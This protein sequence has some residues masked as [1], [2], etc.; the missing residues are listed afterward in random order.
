MNKIIYA[1]FFI[2]ILNSLITLQLI[3]NNSICGDEPQY[4]GYALNLINGNGFVYHNKYSWRPPGYPIFLAAIYSIFGLNSFTAVRIIQSILR[5]LCVFII[6]DL[7]ASNY[8]KKTGIIA[9]LLWAFEPSSLLISNY[10]LTETLFTVILLLTILLMNYAVKKMKLIFIFCG[11]FCY[12]CSLLISDRAIVLLPFIL[13]WLFITIP[14]RKKKVIYCTAL[15]L[16]SALFVSPWSVRNSLIHKQFVFITTHGGK[17]LWLYNNPY[18]PFIEGS[19]SSAY[20]KYKKVTTVMIKG[21]SEAERDKMMYYAGIN[22]IVTNPIIFLRNGVIKFVRFFR[23]YPIITYHTRL[24]DILIGW[25]SYFIIFPAFFVGLYLSFKNK[26]YSLL[27]IM[28]VYFVILHI[29]DQA[30]LRKRVPAMPFI[31]ALSSYA[32]S[33]VLNKYFDWYSRLIK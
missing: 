24:I 12:A 8:D 23:P 33:F 20:Q 1:I 17:N 31:I 2:A 32:Y 4:N 15:L 27:F 5:A 19:T 13:V 9:S 11:G 29:V 26:K 22:F 14:E 18:Y 3:N 25:G 28:V 21:L 6:Y 16:T 10:L 30:D 7:V